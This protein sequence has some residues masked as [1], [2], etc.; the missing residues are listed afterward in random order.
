MYQQALVPEATGEYLAAT[1][2]AVRFAIAAVLFIFMSVRGKSG[3]PTRLEWEQGLG[4][5]FFASSGLFF[6]M[7]GL[8]YTEAST[9]S[10]LS[11]CY[12]LAIPL[13]TCLISRRWPSWPLFFSTLTVA[14]GVAVLAGFGSHEI[15]WGRGEWETLLASLLFSGQILWVERP[16]F[17]GNDVIRATAIM[18]SCIAV[19]LFP[20]SW[21]LSP[22]SGAF[23]RLYSTGFTWALIAV[24]TLACTWAGCWIMNAWQRFV[25][26]HEAGL[27][28]C[29]EPVVASV[30]ALFV[31]AFLASYSGIDYSNETLTVRLLIGGGLILGANVFIQLK[32]MNSDR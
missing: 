27:L 29:I 28:Y 26:A 11:Q 24:L 17:A 15:H 8:G 9:S 16:R 21:A 30:L 5:A 10:F 4:L 31:P 3:R 32:R 13:W 1:S 14:L 12:C 18:C 22:G 23:V 2:L 7:D 19:F 20:I 6:Q 25:T